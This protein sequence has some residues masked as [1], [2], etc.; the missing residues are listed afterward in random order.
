MT[1]QSSRT[2]PT[3][4]SQNREVWLSVA[5]AAAR[6]GNSPRTVKRWIK[7]ELLSAV[8]LPSPK[9][10]GPLRVRLGDVEALIGRGT[11]A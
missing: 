3:I 5:Q 11:L 2:P 8:R 7:A 4:I 6:A 1:H 9:N 10:M